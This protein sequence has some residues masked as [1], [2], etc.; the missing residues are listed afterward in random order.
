MRLEAFHNIVILITFFSPSQFQFINCL[1]M[2]SNLSLT[3]SRLR[4]RTRLSSASSNRSLM[5]VSFS[6]NVASSRLQLTARLLF[7]SAAEI[8]LEIVVLMMGLWRRSAHCGS[9]IWRKGNAWYW[10]I[11]FNKEER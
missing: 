2:A 3:S 9:I 8:N 10:E 6:W 4:S 1:P 5:M 7:Q 11:L